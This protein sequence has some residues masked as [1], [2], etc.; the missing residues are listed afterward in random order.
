MGVKGRDFLIQIETATPGTY[1]TVGGLRSNSFSINNEAVD[2][3]DKDGDTWKQLLE[4][5]GIQSV[6]VK[7]SGVAKVSTTLA[8]IRQA[9]V[10]NTFVP[11]KLV[12]ALGYSL[13]GNFQITS[14]ESAGEYNKEETFS[15]SL[16]SAGT[17]TYADGA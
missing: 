13:T 10:D 1:A 3:T 12:S 4:G 16:D 11:L 15:V 2:I 5:A 7:G 8:E 17:I 6:A 14:F 9:A